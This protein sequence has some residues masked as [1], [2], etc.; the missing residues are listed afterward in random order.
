VDPVSIGGAVAGA[1]S[2]GA[3]AL[4]LIRT[5][6]ETAKTL[7]K[8]E[9][10]SDLV[11]VQLAMMDLLQKQQLLID[12]NGELKKRNAFLEDAFDNKERLETHFNAYWVRVDENTLDGPFST[13][14]WDLERQLLR[15]HM[16]SAKDAPSLQFHCRAT[17]ETCWVTRTFI[18]K[19]KVKGV[20]DQI[21][22]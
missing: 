21:T 8:S 5:A 19:H 18:L 4:G 2:A 16:I 15:M 7:G 17:K 11:E 12:E 10:V 3:H 6:A 22:L 13:Q 14:Q 9:V 20:L 1:I